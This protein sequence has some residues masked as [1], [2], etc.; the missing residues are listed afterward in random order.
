[1]KVCIFITFLFYF[2]SMSTTDGSQSDDTMSCSNTLTDEDV[3]DSSSSPI[4]IL[5][6]SFVSLDLTLVK[7]VEYCLETWQEWRNRIKVEWKHFPSGHIESLKL[8]ALFVKYSWICLQTTLFTP[9]RVMKPVLYSSL[10]MLIETQ[11][12]L[13]L[14][15]LMS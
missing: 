5:R 15:N 1:M 7:S 4:N 6:W 9:F 13:I 14:T 10:S 3:F 8:S 12:A 2:Q 11:N